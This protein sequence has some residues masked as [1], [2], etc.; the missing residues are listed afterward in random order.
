MHETMII[1]GGM[2]ATTEMK[3]TMRGMVNM[4]KA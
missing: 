1:M 4:M 2:I 3:I